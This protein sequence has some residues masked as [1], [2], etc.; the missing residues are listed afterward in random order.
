MPVDPVDATKL[1]DRELLLILHERVGTLSRDVHE[2]RNG[3]TAKIAALE[4]KVEMMQ[5]HK[6]DKAAVDGAMERITTANEIRTKQINTINTRLA[7]A[8]GGL[9]ALQFVIG[10]IMVLVVKFAR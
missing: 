4:S 10:I 9:A 7:F 6:A 5:E 2:V 3:T 1:S 8:A